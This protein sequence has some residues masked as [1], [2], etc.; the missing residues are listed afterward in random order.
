MEQIILSFN[1]LLCYSLF[2][3]KIQALQLMWCK[4]YG[5]LSKLVVSSSSMYN[6]KRTINFF[7]K[8]QLLLIPYYM[9]LST[10][11]YP[12]EQIALSGEAMEYR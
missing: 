9:W 7:V 4:D 12:K 10:E 3:T 5:F 8:I 11:Q 2:F 1:V 6:S